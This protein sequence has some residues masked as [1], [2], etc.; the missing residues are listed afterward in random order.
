MLHAP[1]AGAPVNM[2]VI[3]IAAVTLCGR[4]SP[5]TMGS[6]EDRQLLERMRQETDASLIGAGTLRDGDPEMRGPGN[7]LF[8]DRIRA[9]VSGSGKFSWQEK[10]LFRKGPLPL[11]FTSHDLV[12]ELGRRFGARAEVFGLAAGPGG[13]LLAPALAEMARRGVRRVLVEGGGRMNHSCLAQGL[14]DELLVTLCPRLSGDRS[15]ASLADG[16]TPLGDP[17]MDCELLA[18][19]QGQQGELYL[20]YRVRK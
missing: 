13:L 20:R 10:Q 8:A 14:V 12:A 17:F 6:A 2:K 19:R 7:V 4:I 16:P 1:R 11:I 5:G 9:V 18:V 15:A 3:M